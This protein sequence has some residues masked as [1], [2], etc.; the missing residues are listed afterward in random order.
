[1]SVPI[2]PT[3]L[4]SEFLALLESRNRGTQLAG[5]NALEKLVKQREV[6]RFVRYAPLICVSAALCGCIRRAIPQ[7]IV[8]LKD[9]ESSTR[10]ASG[11]VM[12]KLAEQCK[13]L[14]VLP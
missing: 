1:M 4:A 10:F 3:R 13:I 11:M 12:G 14:V 2:F 6:S 8:M 9:K 5:I 7:I